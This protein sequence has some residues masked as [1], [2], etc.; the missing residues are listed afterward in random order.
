[1]SASP[2]PAAEGAAADRVA[3]VLARGLAQHK[4]G[5]L[6]EA[7]DSYTQVLAL[8]PDQPYALHLLGE[9]CHR[10]GKNERAVEL[11]ERAVKLLP[12]LAEAHNNLGT[13]YQA[14]GRLADAEASYRRAIGIKPSLI[15]AGNN[16]GTVLKAQGNVTE[17]RRQ[18][19]RVLTLD[20]NAPESCLNLGNLLR[21]SGDFAAAEDC[22]RIVTEQHPNNAAGWNNLG[23][24]RCDQLRPEEAR[25]ALERAVACDPNSADAH[26]NLGN[27]L[28]ALHRF[29]E[30]IACYQRALVLRPGYPQAYNNI[31]VALF[32]AGRFLDALPHF[33]KSIEHD[34][35]F[36]EG[37]LNL[38]ACL[39]QVDQ[40]G[41][42]L[43]YFERALEREPESPKGRNYRGLAL[44]EVGRI[45]EGL[46]DCR[47]AF[48]RDPNYGRARS[49]YLF[50]L[51]YKPD[52]KGAELLS[53]HIGFGLALRPP[54]KRDFANP[55]T[56]DRPLRIGYVSPD[57]KR[58]SCAF[59]FEPL[60]A[61][62]DPKAVE[63]HCYS[64]VH[65]PDA[66]TQRIRS[67]AAQWHDTSKMLESAFI[68]R[69][70]TDQI[71]I[72]V[73]LTGHTGNNRLLA[74]SQRIAP[75]QVSW[76]G[77]PCT[78]GLGTIDYRL[79]DSFA[80]PPGATDSHHTESLVRLPNTFLCYRAPDDAPEPG[81]LPVLGGAPFTF[82]SFN[83]LPK[84]NARVIEVWA[85]ILARAPT[86]RLLL[87]SRALADATTCERVQQAF[88]RHGVDPARVE[89]VGWVRNPA[90]HLLLYGKVD[91][92]LDPFPYNGT[93]TTCEAMWMGVPA[94]TL[95]GGRHASRVG[96]SLLKQVGLS[97]F[98]AADVEEYVARAA[99]FAA[100]P[101]PLVEVRAGLRARMATS[102]LC[103]GPAFARDVENAYRAMWRG[104]CSRS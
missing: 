11:I 64:D 54:E 6:A 87:K 66:V 48:K 5:R 89:L 74:F 53:E 90:E 61:A 98:V 10:A 58:H 31:G 32:E 85:E 60:I 30:S 27:A 45:E 76:L 22:Y 93:T 97:D 81:A 42:A 102:P 69:V 40:L 79:T 49:N 100:D 39:R 73:D 34:P 38:G 95:A 8:D 59:F 33:R 84:I 103:D 52:V 35:N 21:E 16:L 101:A 67:H 92:A 82:G 36:V 44:L 2:R 29:D 70:L 104:W 86:A 83:N 55:R 3:T 63:V 51:N 1:M 91:L 96:V 80:D 37:L 23:I 7:L 25:V 46:A 99:G 72:V 4:A 13:A 19:E 50:G 68:E 71:D 56:L 75:V 41:E 15:I 65:H 62:H 24:L 28:R 47:A 9:I 17:A 18:F 14:L 20:P 12:E 78:T 94:L 88:S 43:A 57:F 77:Y 26:N